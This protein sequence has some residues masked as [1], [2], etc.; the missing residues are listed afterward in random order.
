DLFCARAQLDSSAAVEELCRQLDNLPL[1]LEL[2]AARAKVL[3][4][5][6]ILER[7]SQRLD[8][9]KG[10]RDADPRQATLRAAIE[11]SHDLLDEQEQR[12]FRQLGVFAGSFDLDAA[13]TVADADL[14]TLT[15]LLDK[16]LLRR[17]ADGRFFMLETIHEFAVEQLELSGGDTI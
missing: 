11:W 3:T 1:A 4:P 14:D 12:L 2:A 9:L 6:S 8:L 17:T 10:G 5:D 7:L 13:E 16:S 15:A